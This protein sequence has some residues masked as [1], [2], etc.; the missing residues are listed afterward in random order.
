MIC[1]SATL[2]LLGIRPARDIDVLV[3]PELFEDLKNN[4]HWQISPKHATTIDEPEH[5][6]GAKKSLDFM[7]QNYTLEEAL[8][9]AYWHEGIPFM[10]LEMLIDAKTQLGREKDFKDIELIQKYL[11]KQ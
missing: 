9:I 5:R 10:S 6:S 11:N 7:R 2:E 4:R 8:K 1:G 3:S